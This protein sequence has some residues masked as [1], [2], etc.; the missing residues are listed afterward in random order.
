MKDDFIDESGKKH[1]YACGVE[2]VV[3]DGVLIS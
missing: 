1:I 3:E 2:F